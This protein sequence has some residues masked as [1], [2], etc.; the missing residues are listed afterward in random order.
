[1]DQ[2]PGLVRLTSLVYLMTLGQASKDEDY[3]RGRA[4]LSVL[5]QL[6]VVPLTLLGFQVS[7]AIASALGLDPRDRVSTLGLRLAAVA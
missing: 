6:G 5:P 7:S 3:C 4:R 1:M 2:L